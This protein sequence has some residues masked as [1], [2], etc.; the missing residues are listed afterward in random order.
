MNHS[1]CVRELIAVG[2]RLGFHATGRVHGKIYHMGNP[3][4]V[5][6]YKGPA[7]RT[8]RKIARGDQYKYLPIIAFEVAA[9]E[10]EWLEGAITIFTSSVACVLRL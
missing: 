2:N 7:E 1:E 10:H 4:C 9:N 8:L 5:W 3:D 6:Y